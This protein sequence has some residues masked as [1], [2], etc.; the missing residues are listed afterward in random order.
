FD[1]RFS[2]DSVFERICKSGQFAIM[3]G[4]AAINK[5]YKP[6]VSGDHYHTLRT[7]GFLMMMSRLILVIQYGTVLFSVIKRRFRSAILPMSLIIGILMAFAMISLG[8]VLNFKHGVHNR[9]YKI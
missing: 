6:N 3:V 7:I 4:F 5:N 9:G 8:I 1:V 2:R